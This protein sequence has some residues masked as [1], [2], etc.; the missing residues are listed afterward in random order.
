[1]KSRRKWQVPENEPDRPKPPSC[2]N[3]R[4]DCGHVPDTAPAEGGA[5]A[6][7]L[8]RRIAR[9][10]ARQAD[11]CRLSYACYEGFGG[12]LLYVKTDRE[13]LTGEAAL[14][15]IANAERRGQSVKVYGFDVERYL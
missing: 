6:M 14:A 2:G 15:A 3:G 1:V 5:E 11:E 13:R 4:E 9:L 12:P 10:E 8:R 7:S